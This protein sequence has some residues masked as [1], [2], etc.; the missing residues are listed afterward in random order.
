[1]VQSIKYLFLLILA[2]FIFIL[3]LKIIMPYD[4]K[5]FDINL[6]S[7]SN[8]ISNKVIVAYFGSLKCQDSATLAFSSFTNS[9][10]ELSIEE[11]SNIDVVFFDIEN[12]DKDELNS[13]IEYIYASAKSVFIS[14]D[15]LEDITDGSHLFVCANVI[16]IF[17]KQKNLFKEIDL[18]D[19]NNIYK[20]ILKVINK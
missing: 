1:M 20:D 18:Y 12:D 6:S 15:E 14:K 2:V 7:I 3:L 17:D 11:K 10:D 19:K 8:K 13:Y 4:K 9:L 5:I 16:Y